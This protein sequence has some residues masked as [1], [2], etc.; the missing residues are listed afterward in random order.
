MPFAS[1]Q[2]AVVQSALFFQA[3][4]GTHGREL[5]SSD[6]TAAGT[7]LV[8]DIDQTPGGYGSVPGT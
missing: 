8:E 6:G 7:H 4:D 3:S 1:N 2:V 5:W